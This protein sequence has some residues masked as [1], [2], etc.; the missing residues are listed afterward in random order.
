MVED[1][2][3]SDATTLELIELC[4]DQV[5]GSRIMILATARP[6]FDHGFGGHPIV[7]RF[8]LN[9]LGR[10]P[11][12][13]IVDR[14]AG[15]K[16]LPD[17]VV[18]E[19]TVRTDGVPLFIEEL[20]KA[21]L[22]SGR[23]AQTTA[24]F[25]LTTSLEQL[26]IPTTLHDSLMARLDR[27]QPVKEVAQTAACIGREFSFQLLQSIC[28]LSKAG[29]EDALARLLEAELIFRRHHAAEST[30]VFK[31]ALVRDA[32]YESLLKSRRQDIHA[33]LVDALEADRDTAPELLAHHATYAGMTERAIGY[34]QQAGV[35]ALARPAYQEAIGHLRNALALV[36]AMGGGR[37]WLERELDLLVMLAQALIPKFG[38]SAE[39]TVQAY[40]RGLGLVEQLGD[41]PNRFPVLFGVWV[42][43]LVRSETPALVA[44]A[45]SIL[46]LAEQDGGEIPWLMARRFAGVSQ[47]M[48]GNL[49]RSRSHLDFVLS[50]YRPE[51]HS[52][53]AQRFGQ[54]PGAQTLGYMC[55][56]YWAMGLAE[57]AFRYAD[58]AELA[59]EESAHVTTALDVSWNL[60][61][62]AMCIRDDQRLE[63]PLR[64]LLTL[65]AQHNLANFREVAECVEGIRLAGGARRLALP[66]SR[67]DMLR[68]RQPACESTCRSLLRSMHVLCW[69]SSGRAMP[70]IRS[71]WLST[72][73]NARANASRR[74]KSHQVD[75]QVHLA[76]GDRSGGRGQLP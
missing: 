16:T 29:L 56:L 50:V 68:C 44:R 49:R 45:E 10:D 54:D 75:G 5:A 2:H 52:S 30:Y 35:A 6:T 19:I 62:F 7:T 58:A 69:G 64:R 28:T 61:T 60:C 63:R 76:E 1:L 21:V 67:P 15:G 51:N 36:P 74:P 23:L 33:K 24:G 55:N 25:E 13:A 43:H 57:Q 59:A 11:V 41:T 46:E 38:W 12:R 31:H 66:A 22:E 39:V 8:A 70:V 14:L 18:H 40:A 48:A 27:L 42:G 47:M 72:C 4:L 53:L 20:T 32:A 73:W 65:S 3:W 37:V 17:A 9:R 26:A 71:T 34:W